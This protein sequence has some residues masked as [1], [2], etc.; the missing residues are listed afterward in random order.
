MSYLLGRPLHLRRVD[1]YFNYFLFLKIL[2][3]FPRI[4]AALRSCFSTLAVTI[5]DCTLTISY[6][7]PHSPRNAF[8][9]SSPRDCLI[10]RLRSYWNTSLKASAALVLILLGLTWKDVLDSWVSIL[11]EPG[12][13]VPDFMSYL[14]II[15]VGGFG[16]WLL[17]I[18][19]SRGFWGG[20]SNSPSQFI[21]P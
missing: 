5:T 3:T 9:R 18:I 14:C 17:L 2:H 1:N 6:Y 16:S 8:K 11:P 7:Y 19:F 20:S 21:C 10:T 13:S 15:L 12:K 4:V